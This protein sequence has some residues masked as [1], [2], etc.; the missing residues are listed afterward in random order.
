[1]SG[2]V[3]GTL[4]QFQQERHPRDPSTFHRPGRW[5]IARLISP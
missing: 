3:S 2:K 4:V 5:F 1:L